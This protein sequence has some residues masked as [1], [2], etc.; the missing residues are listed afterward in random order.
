[1]ERGKPGDN[2]ASH[3]GL[4]VHGV[5]PGPRPYLDTVRKNILQST[6]LRLPNLGMARLN[7]RT[8]LRIKKVF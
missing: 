2:I 7:T 1:M 6:T 5:N 3:E 4:V 8:L